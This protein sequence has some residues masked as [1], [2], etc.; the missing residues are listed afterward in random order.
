MACLASRL[1]QLNTCSAAVRVDELD[2]GKF[3]ST[4]DDSRV[5]AWPVAGIEQR[6]GRLIGAPMAESWLLIAEPRCERTTHFHAQ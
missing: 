6:T 3:E 1:R 2:A 4:S 5:A